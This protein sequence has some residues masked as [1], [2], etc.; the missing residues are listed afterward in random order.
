MIKKNSR[1]YVSLF[2]YFLGDRVA[3]YHTHDT[4]VCP[5]KWTFN[6]IRRQ[7]YKH[8]AHSH[9]RTYRGTISVIDKWTSQRAGREMLS[10][11]EDILSHIGVIVQHNTS[12]VKNI[13]VSFSTF[14]F[15]RTCNKLIKQESC[16]YW[17]VCDGGVL[18]CEGRE[19][20]NQH[21][22]K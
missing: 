20:G 7:M 21:T 4:H 8:A 6:I 13:H 14:A 12:S 5:C 22:A 11:L 15:F 16:W 10:C 3:L 18:G 1:N 19:G 2:T 17:C 9:T